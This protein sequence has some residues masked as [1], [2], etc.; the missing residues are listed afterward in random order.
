MAQN[1]RTKLIRLAH[2]N[3]ELR[4][5]LLP[6]LAKQGKTADVPDQFVPEW[7]RLETR[8]NQTMKKIQDGLRDY[9]DIMRDIKNNKAYPQRVRDLGARGE[10]TGEHDY[11]RWRI[12]AD[13]LY[14]MEG[15]FED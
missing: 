9:T 13:D 12:I 8:F 15:A 7:K 11:Q 5:H 4:P 1:L 14:V 6:L 3:P 10:N 2:Q